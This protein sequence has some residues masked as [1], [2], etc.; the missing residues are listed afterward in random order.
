MDENTLKLK[1]TVCTSTPWSL[2]PSQQR[3][4]ITKM[5]HR[6]S[7]YGAHCTWK[8]KWKR[9]KNSLGVTFESPSCLFLSTQGFSRS[10][11]FLY[12]FL[13]SSMIKRAISFLED[14]TLG[15]GPLSDT[16]IC[17]HFETRPYWFV[18][19]LR[20]AHIDLF[21]LWDT[22]I[23]TVRR[24]RLS[25]YS[26]YLTAALPNASD[27]LLRRRGATRHRRRRKDIN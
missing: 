24:T 9:K 19:T 8:T 25:G 26:V 11:D 10:L 18:C 6:P 1:L 7:I 23:L 13:S 16:S 2:C 5:R 20:H 27:G 14:E 17:L 15:S 12:I 3:T 4:E 21:A 22:P